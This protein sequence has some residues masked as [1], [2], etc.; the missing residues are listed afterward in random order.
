MEIALAIALVAI[1]A[2]LLTAGLLGWGDRRRLA[3]LVRIGLLTLFSALALTG[4]IGWA[5]RYYVLAGWLVV[6]AGVGLWTLTREPRTVGPRRLILRGAF[7]ALGA[8]L[9]VTPALVFPAYSP[10][11]PTGGLAVAKDTRTVID[12]ARIDPFSKHDTHRLLTVG[13]W[14]PEVE[15][16]QFPLVVFSH[17]ALGIRES[18]E[19]MFTDLASHGYVVASVD[20]TWHALFSTDATGHQVWIDGGYLGEFRREN[21]RSDPEQSLAYYRKWMDVRKGDLDF[22]LDHVLGDT[23]DPVF[24]L[25]DPTRVGLAGHS[26]GGAAV[27]GVARDRPEVLAV[28]AL[29]APFLADIVGVEDGRFTWDPDPYPVAVLNVY[30]DSAWGHLDEWPQYRRNADLLDDPGAHNVHLEGV[31]HLHLTDLSLASPFLTRVLNGQT[32]TGDARQTLERLN[33]YA[34][35]FFDAYLKGD[36]SFSTSSPSRG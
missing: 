17:G 11:E 21:A 22:V 27:L 1:E 20:H 36:G 24:R 5:P 10:I 19:S 26:L 18:N 14:S 28:M 6:S 23:G 13:L 3:P 31:G 34:L 4:V 35:A 2:L 12:T 25:V 16:G 29:E 8:F 32:S 30:S 33:R 15:E 7:A 9:A